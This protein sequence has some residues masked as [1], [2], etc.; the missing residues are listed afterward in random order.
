[1]NVEFAYNILDILQTMWDAAKQMEKSYAARDMDTF[2]SL[3]KDLSGGWLQYRRS[4]S[5][6][7]IIRKFVLRMP[8]SAPWNH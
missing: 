8:V 5:R 3:S 1:M 7:Q 4:H 2:Y 6:R